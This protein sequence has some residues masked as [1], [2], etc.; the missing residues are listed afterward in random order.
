MYRHEFHG[1]VKAWLGNVLAQAGESETETHGLDS[2]PHDLSDNERLQT[3]PLPMFG[4]PPPG[5]KDAAADA[6]LEAIQ[7]PLRNQK[8]DGASQYSI[9]FRNAARL[10]AAFA[11]ARSRSP[12]KPLV[13]AL[14]VVL[15]HLLDGATETDGPY[16]VEVP[17]AERDLDD[18][19]VDALFEH[20]R[21]ALQEAFVGRDREAARKA[22]A[23]ALLALRQ[24]ADDHGRRGEG[25]P[26]DELADAIGEGGAEV[27]E[28]LA[29]SDVRL[30]ALEQRGGRDCYVLSHDSLAV[31]V[32][33]LVD[34]EAPRGDLELDDR[35]VALRQIVVQR[36]ALQQQD[37][38]SAV[39]LRRRDYNAIEGSAGVLLWNDR[40]RAWWQA[41]QRRQTARRRTNLGWS[42]ASIV[43]IVLVAVLV[44]ALAQSWAEQRLLQQIRTILEPG[45]LETTLMLFVGEAGVDIEELAPYVAFERFG[46]EHHPTARS[47]L[48]FGALVGVIDDL[49]GQASERRRA[50]LL[51]LRGS[52][53]QRFIEATSLPELSREDDA[54][55]NQQ[56][57]LAGKFVMGSR[58]G[59]PNEAPE[60]QVTLSPFYL[61]QHEVT[62]EE[63]R[64][65]DPEH[66]SGA[67]DNHP[68]VEVSWY[69]AMAYAAW[70]GGRLPTEA[71]WEFA[72]RGEKGRDYPWG[73]D[74]PT[75]AHA[76]FSECIGRLA[77]VMKDRDAGKTPDGVYDLSG[78]AGEWCGDRFGPYE[79]SDQENPAGA[80]VGAPDGM[81]GGPARVLRG[82]SFLDYPNY[83]RSAGRDWSH[84]E[85]SNIL[86]GFRVSWSASGGP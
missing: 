37:D 59:N 58:E 54:A 86:N 75:C 15:R 2:L 51:D 47:R 61:Q 12:T 11:R 17:E 83:L 81:L 71:Q 44:A 52:V 60:H 23:R 66:A 38:E 76:Q 40:Q 50:Q 21:Q 13:P 43:G 77:P 36:T 30:I 3:W 4:T 72:A 48:L 84:P 82:G 64:R 35:I 69:E 9:R 46:E 80:V 7:R 22:R 24:L 26:R 65:F 28:R 68:V 70:L 14:Q 53:R 55:R 78:N 34:E 31:V 25:M 5:E 49:A 16:V 8:P 63:Y 10:A 67:P 45:Q 18:L 19:I 57:R 6:F 39:D 74:D 79:V 1:E 42:L 29:S 85:D 20:V 33:R 56:I 27:L 73:A 41:C 32:K 62:N